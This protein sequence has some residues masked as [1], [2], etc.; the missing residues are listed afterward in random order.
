[1]SHRIEAL[2]EML[3]S[4]FADRKS[5][6][7]LLRVEEKGIQ[8]LTVCAVAAATALGRTGPI[9]AR[10]FWLNILESVDLESA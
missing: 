8:F 9:A 6:D 5:L 1:M 7:S 10:G 3:A 4:I 2:M